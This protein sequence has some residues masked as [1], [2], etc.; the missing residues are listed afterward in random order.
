MFTSSVT[1]MFYVLLQKCLCGDVSGG[2]VFAICNTVVMADIW[3]R[4][5]SGLFKRAVPFS[6]LEMCPLCP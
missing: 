2:A 5:Y 3:M 6:I 1:Q 4:A